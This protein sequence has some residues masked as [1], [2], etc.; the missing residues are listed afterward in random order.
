MTPKKQL[1]WSSSKKHAEV[2]KDKVHKLKQ[3][4]AIK[5]VFCPKRLANTVVVKKKS[6]KWRVYVDFTD[7]NKACP[8]DLSPVPRIDQ[9]VDATFGHP[10]ISSLNAFQRYHQIPLALLDREKT[11]FLTLTGNYHYRVMPFS[12]KN[13]GFTYQRL[14]CLRANWERTWRHTLMIWW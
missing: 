4:G 7:L 5:K 2:V 6:E 3:A 1:P 9:L 10:R 11:T 13:A 14:G 12:L 8:K